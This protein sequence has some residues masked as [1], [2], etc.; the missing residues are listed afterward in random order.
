LWSS[1]LHSL[2][3]ILEILSSIALL[4]LSSILLS[5]LLSIL[6]ISLE[7]IWPSLELIVE[8]GSSHSSS[9]HI[10]LWESHH[11]WELTSTKLCGHDLW[12]SSIFVASFLVVLYFQ[13]KNFV[14]KDI[15]AM[16][17]ML[18]NLPYHLEVA[19]KEVL[20]SITFIRICFF[21]LLVRKC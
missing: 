9:H 5:S 17:G 18:Q 8:R 21:V 20:F 6:E 10:L 11:R 15:M 7:L 2:I 3:S 4:E 12:E 14:L 1:L 16:V 19:L 13:V